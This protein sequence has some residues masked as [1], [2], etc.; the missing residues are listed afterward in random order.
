MPP[1]KDPSWPYPTGHSLVSDAETFVNVASEVLVARA[2]Q[3]EQVVLGT[4]KRP[5]M[6][7][8]LDDEEAYTKY[9]MRREADDPASWAED[10]KAGM[11]VDKVL[12]RW[13][14]LEERYRGSTELADASIEK[15]VS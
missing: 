13:T 5:F 4:E 6:Q 11:P 9:E 10:L 7:V 8:P 15:E 14:A 3:L 12:K 1:R 2:K